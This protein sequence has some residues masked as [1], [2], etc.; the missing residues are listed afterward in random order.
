MG[1]GL[2]VAAKRHRRPQ[3]REKQAQGSE[4]SPHVVLRPHDATSGAH[5]RPPVASGSLVGRGPLPEVGHEVEPKV[6]VGHKA[7]L[8]LGLEVELELPVRGRFDRYT[9]GP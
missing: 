7:E 6:E 3:Q 4:A 9:R 1:W 5:M 2:P 8:E